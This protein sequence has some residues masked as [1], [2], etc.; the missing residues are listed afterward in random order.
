ML[1]LVVLLG[2]VALLARRLLPRYRLPWAVPV[3]LV[4]GLLLVRTAGWL[5]GQDG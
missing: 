5:L 1:K 3:A 4:V 2:V